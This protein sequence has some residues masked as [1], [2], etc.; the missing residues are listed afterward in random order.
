MEEIR[1]YPQ[2]NDVHTSHH[3]REEPMNI[4]RAALRDT[5]SRSAIFTLCKYTPCDTLGTRRK[6]AATQSS[7]AS[8]SRT[9]SESSTAQPSKSSTTASTTA[10][11]ESTPLA[12]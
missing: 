9:Q 6:T 12:W 10:T 2:T 11:T 8:H 1:R 7:M 3:G 5:G 4:P